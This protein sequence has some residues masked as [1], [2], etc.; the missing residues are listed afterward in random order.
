[1][2]KKDRKL[3]PVQDYRKL[4]EWT[5]RNTYPLPLILE[6]IARVKGAALFSK[7]DVHWGY[8]NIRIRQGD[9]WKAAFITN[10]GLFK[11]KVMFF[12]LT[13]SPATFQMMMNAIFEE[14]LCEDWLTIYMDDI[15]IHTKDNLEYHRKKVHHILNKLRKNN[16]FLKPEKCFFEQTEMKFLGVIL[17]PGTIRMDP[18][19]F[20]GIVD[21]SPPRTVKGVR[22]FL[23]F[24]GFYRYFIPGYSQ[25]AHPLID[26]MKKDMPWHWWE[27]QMKAFKT[28]KTLMCRQPILQQPDYTKQFFLAM[29]AS[30]YGVGAILLQEGELNPHTKLPT[31]HPITYYLATFTPTK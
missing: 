5:I 16:L 10:K 23:R 17:G 12:R 26:L 21:W 29:D 31:R 27:P 22:A 8:N 13:N 7:F 19:K 2:K 14:E 11:P 24:T 4:N 6:L 15:L 9:E 30:A 18:T 3:R 20:K 25:I 28:L 1:M